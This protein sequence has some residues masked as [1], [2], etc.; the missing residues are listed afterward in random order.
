MP[1][2][3]QVAKV[4]G[5]SKAT[6]SRVLNDSPRISEKTR[7]RVLEVVRA[8]D[9]EPNYIARSLSK[10][11]T[12]SIGVVLEDIVN[13]FYT[14]VA[15][16]IETVLRSGGYTMLLTSSGYVYEEELE[17]TRTLLRYK[18]DG[19]LITPVQADSLAVNIL[20]SRGV[21]FFIMNAKSDDPEVNWIDSDNRLGG[22]LATRHLLGLGHRRFLNLYSNRLQ[23]SRDRL[24]GFKQAIAEKGLSLAEQ[25]L[26][27]DAAFREDGYR[28]IERFVRERGTAAL[29]TAIVAVNDASAIGAMECLFEHGVRIP[30]EVSII[31]YDDIY[32]ASLTRVPLTTIHQSKFRMG[33]IAARGLLEM[34]KR[35]GPP[36]EGHHFLIH[37]K[38]VVRESCQEPGGQEAT[39]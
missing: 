17:L 12:H 22:Y 11:K 28:L 26:L 32:F 8:L 23:G 16:G 5:V 31:G 10:Q 24:E 18:A 30:Q 21:P 38:L 34:I 1:T 37:P 15:K 33:E 4:A 25:V 7:A 19:I 35:G 27:G 9:Y 36:A 3:E 20:R 14:Q 6:V 13:P 2:M 29:P 39:E